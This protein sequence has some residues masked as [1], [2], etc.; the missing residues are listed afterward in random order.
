MIFAA[1]FCVEYKF[2]PLFFLIKGVKGLKRENS[3][4]RRNFES[5]ASEGAE[6]RLF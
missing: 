6:K 3:N 1:K 2:A 5:S 4:S